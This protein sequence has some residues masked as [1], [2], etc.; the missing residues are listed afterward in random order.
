MP[1]E[2]F[3]AGVQAYLGALTLAL[4]ARL[5]DDLIGVCLFGSAAQ[6]AYEP[7]LSDLDVQAVTRRTL[8]LETR[9]T[10][11]ADLSHAALPCPAQGLEFVLYPAAAV[12]PMTAAPAF[13]LNLNTGSHRAQHVGLDAALEEP[14]WFVLDIALGRE[15][16][17]ALWGPPPAAMFGEVPRPVILDALVQSQRWH[18]RHDAD[19]PN[20][21]LNAART[22][23]FLDTGEWGS[24]PG[25]VAWA[26]Q[27][28]RRFPVIAQ[29]W[30]VRHGPGALDPAD[31]MEFM[32]FLDGRL[33]AALSAE[34]QV[35]PAPGGLR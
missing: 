34:R 20:R 4:R 15:R 16:G 31:V 32:T 14:H 26:A 12:R 8:P 11:A 10:I 25:G 7:G 35:I 23:R 33:A 24:K 19:A 27:Q 22:W 13:D 29:A 30:S 1:A 18:A 17:R 9:H 21:V 5:G 2:E 6:G 28:G 3:P